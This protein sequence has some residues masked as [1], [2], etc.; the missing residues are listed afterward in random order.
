VAKG[1]RGIKIQIS[2]SGSSVSGRS[3]GG[4]EKVQI[5]MM[6]SREKNIAKLMAEVD[7]L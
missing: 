2:G 5:F 3:H 6:V 4:R 1:S 7:N